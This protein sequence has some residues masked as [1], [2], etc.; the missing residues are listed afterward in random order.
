MLTTM[1]AKKPDPVLLGLPSPS[2]RKII[3]M[4]ADEL[5]AHVER[6]V[7]EATHIRNRME[8]L[9]ARDPQP[10][11]HLA[12]LQKQLERLTTLEQI[13]RDKLAGKPSPFLEQAE[14]QRSSSPR[15][16]NRPTR[17]YRHRGGSPR[18]QQGGYRERSGGSGGSSP[19]S[20]AGG[21]SGYSRPRRDDDTPRNSGNGNSPRVEGPGGYE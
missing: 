12:M 6:I 3:K 10:T 1:A 14:R 13:G 9:A 7:G 19:S 16:S 18:A 8:A 17:G 20:G 5:A 4:D 11:E 2:L 15:P 21:Y